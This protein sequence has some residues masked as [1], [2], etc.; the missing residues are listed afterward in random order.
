MSH[1]STTE[2]PKQPSMI[3]HNCGPQVLAFPCNQFN[4]QE[5]G[6][7][8]SIQEFAKERNIT[9]PLFAK[10]E[11][12]GPATHPVFKY[13]KLRTVD[14]ASIQGDSS[15]NISWNF[16]KFLVNRRGVPVKRYPS[17]FEA[18]ILEHDIIQLLVRNELVQ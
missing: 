14:P 1:V 16:N 11:V 3:K 2:L 8:D 5:P 17:E 9:F 4:G 10:A 12:N 13:L 6:S 7:P 15:S 18:D